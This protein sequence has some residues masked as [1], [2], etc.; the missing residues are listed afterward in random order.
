MEVIKKET[1]MTEVIT[2]CYDICDKC[3]KRISTK[4]GDAFEFSLEYKTGQS[5]PE[6][7]NG[8]KKSLDLCQKCAPEAIKLLMDNGFSIQTSEWDW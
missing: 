8:V 2:E 7:G 1:K 4:F 5:Y 6:G 3:G